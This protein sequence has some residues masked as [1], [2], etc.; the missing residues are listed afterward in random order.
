MTLGVMALEPD[1]PSTSVSQGTVVL[2][3]DSSS[4]TTEP[5]TEPLEQA[6]A[7]GSPSA[8]TP[9][10]PRKTVTSALELL[11]SLKPSISDILSGSNG[12][13]IPLGI[14][15]V[16][17][18]ERMR[19][20]NAKPGAPS[21]V[22]DLNSAIEK[23]STRNEEE[24]DVGAGV[25]FLGPRQGQVQNDDERR[26]LQR[27]CGK[28]HLYPAGPRVLNTTQLLTYPSRIRSYLS[29][30]QKRGLFNGYQTSEGNYVCYLIEEILHLRAFYR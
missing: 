24:A 29:N 30:F 5:V 13:E 2:P 17:N 7:E 16:F 22:E 19:V 18:T 28:S 11:T 21:I 1:E 20:P 6:A 14:L 3:G 8:D 15:H 12:V 4:T 9:S 27:V 25:L 26:K 23:G 10:P